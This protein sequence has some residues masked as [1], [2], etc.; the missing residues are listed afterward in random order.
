MLTHTI[1]RTWSGAGSSIA[2]SVQLQ[3][4]AEL[5][6]DEAIPDGTT[7]G[8]VAFAMDV[9][10]LKA[11]FIKSDVAMTIK[12]NSSGSPV[13]TITL[14]ANTPF[15]WAQGDPALRDTGNTAITTDITALYVTNASGNNG[16]LQ[17]RALYDPTV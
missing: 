8:L 17:I 13:N 6:I 15:V 3:G 11:L 2:A 9:S 12:T 14:A 4:G 16:T 7:N 10:Q 1:N 5:N